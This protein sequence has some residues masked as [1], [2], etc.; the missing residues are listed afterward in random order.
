MAN[1]NVTPYV[2]RGNQRFINF[3][4]KTFNIDNG[5]GTTDDDYIFAGLPSDFYVVSIRPVYVEA[6]DTAGAASA[7][8][9]AG[10]TAGGAE[11]V[12]A[13]ALEVSKAVGSAGTAGTLVASVVPAGG[14]LF[15]RHTGVASTEAGQYYI[16]V[17]GM[18]KP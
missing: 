5:A 6:T 15:I 12:A 14:S 18:L 9:K 2:A 3:R 17:L 8:W 16:Q 10:T 4:S 7:N 1:E 13:T 11:I